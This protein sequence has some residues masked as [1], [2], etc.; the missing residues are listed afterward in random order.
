VVDEIFRELERL[1]ALIEHNRKTIAEV[2]ARAVV[3]DAEFYK[4]QR[5]IEA[6]L[7]LLGAQG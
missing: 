3:L 2:T 1:D 6:D 5:S 7:R 4:T